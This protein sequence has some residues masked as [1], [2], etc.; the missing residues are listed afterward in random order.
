MT[1]VGEDANGD[2]RYH[3]ARRG[4]PKNDPKNGPVPIDRKT[5]PLRHF[6]QFGRAEAAP[7][8]WDRAEAGAK[9]FP[10]AHAVQRRAGDAAWRREGL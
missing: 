9:R 5:F 4:P 7:G 10:G 8:G 6:E 1:I 2:N 3:A